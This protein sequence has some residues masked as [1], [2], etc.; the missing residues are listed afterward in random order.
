MTYNEAETRYFL[1]D[2]VLREKRYDNYQCLKLE[3]PAPV[4]PTGPK[5]RQLTLSQG[6]LA[7]ELGVSYATVNRWEN[8]QARPS[9]LDKAQFDSFCSKMVRQG[10]LKLSGG[11]K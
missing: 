11:D 10:K 6:D 2:P 8:V 9:K 5:G 3:I 1:I 4:E 7:R